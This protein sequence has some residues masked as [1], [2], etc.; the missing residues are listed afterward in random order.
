V[1]CSPALEPAIGE[2]DRVTNLSFNGDDALALECEG[3]LLDSLGQVGVDP[4]V[5]WEVG[6]ASTLNRTLRRRCGMEAG[7]R[8]PSD[9]FE[10][11]LEWLSFPEDTFDGLGNAA[12]E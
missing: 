11:A 3:T 10:P 9:A 6:D 8:E 4:G 7:D 1:L 5:A 12:C 2:C